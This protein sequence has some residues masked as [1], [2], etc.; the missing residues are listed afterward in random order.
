MELDKRKRN[1]PS[2]LKESELDMKRPRGRPVNS[3]FDSKLSRKKISSS[4]SKTSNNHTA[5]S[6]GYHHQDNNGLY[7]DKIYKT[8]VYRDS[9][10]MYANSNGF[11]RTG[12]DL[13]STSSTI[14]FLDTGVSDT[15]SH[16]YKMTAQRTSGDDG[17]SIYADSLLINSITLT[18]VAVWVQ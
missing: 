4:S 13:K 7:V 5:T 16:T 18:E 6:S 14:R 3:S 17:F 15:N 1:L 2:K 11:Y 10:E 12:D 8:R 9:T